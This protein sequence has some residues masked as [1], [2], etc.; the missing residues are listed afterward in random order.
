MRVTDGLQRTVYSDETEVAMDIISVLLP[1]SSALRL[2]KASISQGMAGLVVG[3]MRPAG[4]CPVCGRIG[5]RVHNHYER[6]LLGLP[7]QGTSVSVL[8]R[9]RRFFCDTPGCPRQFFPERLTRIAAPYARRTSR[10]GDIVACL[11]V[12]L[13]GEGGRRLAARLGIPVS[14]NTLLRTVRRTVRTSTATPPPCQPPFS[15]PPVGT[16]QVGAAGASGKC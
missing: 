3:S 14:A 1:D 11:G 2:K 16:R 5:T 10:K 15:R 6:K 12:A 7:W 4:V 9:T 8:W 13:G